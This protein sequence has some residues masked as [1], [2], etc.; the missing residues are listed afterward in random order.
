[1]EFMK[2]QIYLEREKLKIDWYDTLISW[3]FDLIKIVVVLSLV[4]IFGI[5]LGAQVIFDILQ[6][7]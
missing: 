3:F 2:F 7:L 1:M 5:Y 4:L 6:Q